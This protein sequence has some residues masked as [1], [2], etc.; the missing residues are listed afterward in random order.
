MPALRATLSTINDNHVNMQQ[1]IVE[2]F[3]DGGQLRKLAEPTITAT[4]K[5]IPGL[6]LDNAATCAHARSRALHPHRCR[7]QL[8][9]GR[10]SPQSPRCLG[11][12]G[13]RYTLAL[14]YDLSKLRAKSLV[15]KLPHSRRYRFLPAVTR[16]ASCFSSSSSASTVRLPRAFFRLSAP[17][18]SSAAKTDCRSTGSI[19]ALSTIS[20]PSFTLSGSKPHNSPKREQN[21]RYQRHN[22]LESDRRGRQGSRP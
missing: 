7:Q 16:S 13:G 2:T 10:S 15:E 5:R 17:T 11:A 19:N 1:D 6:K 20:T 18:L 9:D 12:D 22:G 3:V 21:P 14:R 8:Y 4:G